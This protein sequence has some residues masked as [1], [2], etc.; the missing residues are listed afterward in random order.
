MSKV[1]I[2]I[3]AFNS[4]QKTTDDIEK[5]VN[6]FLSRPEIVCDTSDV[7]FIPDEY[8]TVKITYSLKSKTKS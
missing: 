7:E 6:A 2:K 3:F 1:R 5:E 4:S 8:T